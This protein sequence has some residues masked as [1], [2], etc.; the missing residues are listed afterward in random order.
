MKATSEILALLRQYLSHLPWENT[1]L[2]I[3]DGNAKSMALLYNGQK[4][5]T[6]TA[7]NVNWDELDNCHVYIKEYGIAISPTFL[8][9][10]DLFKRHKKGW[11][12]SL[13]CK[14]VFVT[15]SPGLAVQA[16]IKTMLDADLLYIAHKIAD[17]DMA[18]APLNPL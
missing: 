8:T 15:P 2:E 1:V 13:N 7:S 11:E 16:A 6:V 5:A 18:T 17:E 14:P 3:K 9:E 10:K 12:V 4:V